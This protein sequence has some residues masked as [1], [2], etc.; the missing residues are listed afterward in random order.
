MRKLRSV[1]I[2]A[3]AAALLAVTACSSFTSNAADP[4]SGGSAASAGVVKADIAK[5]AH[6]E[7]PKP[8][9]TVP[10]LSKRPP[11]G[12]TVDIINCSV[13]VCALYT[14]A[15]QQAA[16]ALGWK[17]KVLTTQFTPESYTATWTSVVQDKPNVVFAAAILPSSIV[18]AQVNA[19]HAEGAIILPYAGDAPAGPGSPYLFSKANMPEQ[20]QQGVVQGLIAVADAHGAPNVLFLAV[21]DTPSAAP[22]GAAL[23]LTVESAGG[24]YRA[25]DVNTADIGSKA[26]AEVVSYLQAHP[27]ITYVCL[28]WDDWISG[29]PQALKSAGLGSIK[30]I[31]T[32]ADAASESDV[33]TGL[34]FR[35]VVHPTAQNAWWMMDAAA[36]QMVGDPIG[37]PNPPGPVAV[38]A[39]GDV[40]ALGDASSWPHI[41]AMFEAAW[42]VG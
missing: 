3:S 42:H 34:M 17:T 32:A 4:T 13:P 11:A 31:G 18:Q 6:Y 15:A 19:L 8:A 38:V 12:K 30:V 16:A 22:T 25:I 20:R 21:P 10:A 5:L 40:S 27:D 14:R 33:A 1:A 39:P 26:P 29:L 41:N 9:V 23:K 36:R 35:S 37:D 28:P 7:N 24:T 2:A